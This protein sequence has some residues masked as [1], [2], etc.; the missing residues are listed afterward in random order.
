VVFDFVRAKQDVS[1]F[2][3][4]EHE[5]TKWNGIVHHSVE[6]RFVCVQKKR[7]SDEGSLHLC[8]SF[9]FERIFSTMM[10]TLEVIIIIIG[11]LMMFSC[12]MIMF[13]PKACDT[14]LITN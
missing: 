4:E 7:K 11:Y 10:M 3:G 14:E 8:R 12:P 13:V 5:K 6:F 1:F 9:P 2:D